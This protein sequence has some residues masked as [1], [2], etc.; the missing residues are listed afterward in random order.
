MF[1]KYNSVS[2]KHRKQ[3]CI[4]EIHSQYTLGPKEKIDNSTGD[5]YLGSTELVQFK[6]NLWK[7]YM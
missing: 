2:K 1:F 4:S 7:K 3:K 5:V 6:L